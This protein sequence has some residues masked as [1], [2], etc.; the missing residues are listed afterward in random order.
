VVLKDI[1]IAAGSATIAVIMV[2]GIAT[3][4]YNK[5][6]AIYHACQGH[7]SK[8]EETSHQQYPICDLL[9]PIEDTN[10]LIGNGS[11]ELESSDVI[12]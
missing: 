8:P 10:N 9:L 11:G 2:G 4:I 12:L 5:G 6:T 7:S 3:Y 1:L